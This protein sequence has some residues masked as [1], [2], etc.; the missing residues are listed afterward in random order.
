MHPALG[1]RTPLKF[2]SAALTLGWMLSGLLA[3]PL[4]GQDVRISEFM[5]ANTKT[6][7][8]DI[9]LYSDWIELYNADTVSVNLENWTLTDDAG[10]PRQWT[11]PATNLNAGAYLV[12]FA[13]G[14]DHRVP[15][16]PL[17]TNFKLGASRGYL[18]L[19]RPDG[20][21]ATAYTYPAQAPNISYG[22]GQL[23]T[24]LTLLKTN[25]TGRVL[26]PAN[27]NEGTN[28]T[29]LDYNDSAW[30]AALNGIGFGPTNVAQADYS[31]A[32]QPT[33]PVGYW[34]FRETTG[35]N[36]ANDG[37]G[38][39]LDGRYVNATLGS[40]GPRPSQ[41]KGFES[42]NRA[43]TFSVSRGGYVTVSN[44]ILN[45]RGAF[46]LGGWIKPGGTPGN[47]AGLFGQ[48]GCV[49]FGFLNASNLE[50]RTLS[51]GSVQA[52]YTN[53]A[54][55][56]HHV[57]AQG[58]GSRLQIYIDGVLA[59]VGGIPTANYG[60][61]SF[62]FNIGGGGIQDAAGNFFN[63]QV[64]EVVV[65]HRALADSEIKLLYQ[66]GFSAVNVPVTPYV[67]TDLGPAMS[68]R[69]ASAYL[70]LPFVVAEP[71]NV[72]LLILRVRFN[73]GFVAYLNGEQVA[74]MNAPD[75]PAYDSAATT[76]HL[77]N[78]V[79]EIR[80]GPDGL[81]PGTNVLAIQGLNRAADDPDFLLAAELTGTVVV[82]N[83]SIPVYFT[84]PT[85]GQANGSGVS[86][87]GPAIVEDSH[88][89]TV[90]LDTEDLLVTTRVNATFYPVTNVVMRY[91][92]M[93]N[94]EI[95]LRM[96]DDGLHG[97]GAAG[98]GLYGAT[99]P[100]SASTN[101]QMVRWFFRAADSR[102]NVSRW[103]LFTD[104]G[105]T[106]EYLGTIVN[107]T[108][109]TSQLPIIH[110]FASAAA[111]SGAEDSGKSGGRV[112]LFYDGEFYD[113][114][115][116]RVRGNSTT[117]YTK[118]SH[119][120]IFNSEH[121]F[122]H[123]PQYP[124]L[125]HTSFEADYAD[126]A[127]MRQGV[128]FWLANQ[129]GCPA[130]FYYSV[131][132]QMNNAFYQLAC[133]NDLHDEDLLERL[134]YDPNGALYNAAGTVEPSKFSTGGFDKKTRQWDTTDADYYAL[135]RAISETNTPSARRVN[136]FEYFD[137]PNVINYLVLARFVHENDDVWAN[138]SLYHD[139][140][141]D[142]LWRIIPFDMNL[143]WGAIFY[144]GG[145][146]SVIEGVQATND[147]H[148]G[149]PLYG[150]SQTPA[151]NSGN[152]NRVY[153][154]IFL[155]PETR[156]M[157]LRRIR[158][159]LDTWV[160]PPGTHPLLLPIEKY[161]RAWRDLIAVEA[162]L[163]RAKWGWPPKGGQSNFDPGI[164][165][166]AGVD[167]L[168]NEFIAKRRIHFYCKHSITNKALAIGTTKESN[169]GI[170]LAQ[171]AAAAVAI[172]KIEYNPASGNQAEEFICVTNPN[173][174]AIDISGWKLG[175][176]VEFTFRPGTVIPSNYV[177][178]VAADLN[179]FRARATA[180]RG[181]MGLFVQGS[182]RGQLSAR[183]EPLTITDDT[184]RLVCTNYFAGNPSLV[185]QYLRITE[186]MYNPSPWGGGADAQQYEYVELRNI[187][188]N[189]T[190]DLAGVY[191]ANGIQ[192][193][194]ANAAIT[195]LA[196]GARVLVV[197]S[198]AAFAAR[199]GAGQPVAGQ[200]TGNLDNSGERIVLRDASNEEILDFTYQNNWHP[201]T[202]GAGFSLVI[203]NENALPEQWNA[204]TNWRPS[205]VEGGSPGQADSLVSLP[206]PVIITEVLSHTDTP[207][208]DAVEL[209]NPAGT[210][211]DIGGWFLSD[212]LATPKK[213]RIPDGT[214]LRSG[215]YLAFDERQFNANA[216][217][218]ASFAFS[219]KG[220]QAYLF[221]G[222]ARTNLTGYVFGREFGAAES[223]VS[224]GSYTNSLGREFFTAQRGRTLPGP[225]S[226]PLV[227]PV[228]ISEIMY[229]PPDLSN[230]GDNTFYEYIVLKII[231][232][233]N[234]PLYDPLFP[235]N[236][237]RMRGDVDF[238]FPTNV[239]LP[240]NQALFLVNFAPADND[241]Q[242]AFRAK[243]ALPAQALCF[244][245]YGGKL[246]NS[247]G[248]LK[249]TKPDAPVQGE[250]PYVLVET[251]DFSD[252][253]PWSGGADGTGASLQRLHPSKFAND[254]T[255]WIAAAPMA[256]DSLGHGAPP[257]I[258]AHPIGA[259]VVGLTDYTLSVTATGGAPLGYQWHLDG[260]ALGGATNAAL[261][262]TNIQVD[263]LGSYHVAV[264]NAAGVALSQPAR[265][266]LLGFP[267]FIDR[268][269]A[270]LVV[271][272]GSNATFSVSASSTSIPRYQWRFNGADLIGAT[273]AS[274]AITNAQLD[275]AGE[276]RVLVTDL[277]GQVLSDPATLAVLV[278]PTI[279]E[280]PQSAILAAGQRYNLGVAV[281][282]TAT[283]PVFY[284]L[285]RNNQVLLDT[286]VDQPAAAYAF[287]NLAFGNSGSYYY[288][289][290]NLARYSSFLSYTAFVAVALPPTNLA[291]AAGEDAAF[292]VVVGNPGSLSR[293]ARITYQWRFN[294][295]DLTNQPIITKTTNAGVLLATN[296]LTLPRVQSS[297]AGEYSVLVSV[298]T[299][300]PVT[301]ALFAATLSVG[302]ALD[303][304][305][306]GMPDDWELAHG[307]DSI[308][309]DGLKDADGDGMNNLAEY[310]AGTDPGDSQSFLKVELEKAP[311]AAQVAVRFG[312]ISNKTYSVLYQAGLSSQAPWNKLADVASAPTN[313]TVR[314][315]DPSPI[316]PAR[317][318]RL[319]TPRTQ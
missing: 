280:H 187:S 199:Y 304:D 213:Y 8:D 231:T 225:N 144:E 240:P 262:V 45:Y 124:R 229:H 123:L 19:G 135:A 301:P 182:Y 243:Y 105:T 34:R 282:N 293:P 43:P 16:A 137:L 108:N 78:V 83:S 247:S 237:W 100:A 156:Q 298:W 241:K 95:E 106:A 121:P 37:S 296:T 235:A 179:A 74:S 148:K 192:F 305:G 268:Q 193:A 30:Q 17:H 155:T 281:T 191:F 273:N 44:S 177:V 164:G 75:P 133:H 178:Y 28:W 276:Y 33:E 261:T 4:N 224:F 53:A 24:N 26:V 220:D 185:Q 277:I 160:K 316:A 233:T 21:V 69:N 222:D 300:M 2:A 136:N 63:G 88:W 168:I 250:V 150:S 50:C 311:G 175:G 172:T 103:P 315:P 31:L 42:D 267:A 41:F 189:A 319:V 40:Y 244:G 209:F 22:F 80:L 310:L 236:T 64:D 15:G 174:Y 73:D 200:Y 314:V 221:S 77:V 252:S 54:N 62:N 11:F 23:L 318:Y 313:R 57:I 223:G 142:G 5:A 59:G 215:E 126:P 130:P 186:L 67:N 102:N 285:R 138:M 35:T 204:A 143:S 190:L 122:R 258:T 214:V 27:G 3:A 145:V 234:V 49:E 203:V 154:T 202:D 239:T 264:F 110:L 183:G 169:A 85:P 9:H 152:Y 242:Q 127:Y 253:A 128:T 139:N 68:N 211:V 132:L 149:H 287:T 256:G 302:T 82:A 14:A 238:D 18:A 81:T 180:P 6:L 93:F 61:S 188:S 303:R 232:N 161:V 65:Y 259:E 289:V 71:T 294:G 10:S 112:A 46:A 208:V 159:L 184:G 13:S 205:G 307:L 297:Q 212:D 94:S 60:G 266:S 291:V 56:W 312:A 299:N 270:D 295:V 254:P 32:V 90:P 151:L 288:A 263:Q 165:L 91:R 25:S 29:A 141:G 104:P 271:R 107:P 201:V 116:M 97:D 96:F 181:G 171:P 245:P 248:T 146:P 47:L 207:L 197:Q 66:A 1:I 249:L 306:D 131:R 99:I 134:G 117:G 260:R 111:L 217:S 230:G 251:V 119:R 12:V 257:S 226:G 219:A 51:G 206:A 76:P 196:P 157:F 109:L 58:D 120:V 286:M 275:D 195:Q 118:K 292:A 38:A 84:R 272:S 317:F 89:P 308:T 114:I 216:N 246:D 265:I 269:P 173:P 147:I 194:F 158:T 284:R 218:P 290:T 283:L 72:T 39:G 227:G 274:L 140:D 92:V 48:H 162:P 7:M 278:E 167:G 255:N 166:N 228:V 163:D 55:T 101:G 170:P 36:T 115:F 52:A 125:R 20:T 176:G 153:D 86:I 87:L 198:Q 309:P 279:V 70:R 210:N 98:D 79:E 129:I 113:N